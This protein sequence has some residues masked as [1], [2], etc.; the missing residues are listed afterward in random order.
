MPKTDRKKQIRESEILDLFFRRDQKAVESVAADYGKLFRR[1]AFNITRDDMTADEVLNDTYLALWNSIPPERPDNLAAYGSAV[2]RN[3]AVGRV[4]R[5]RAAKR[6]QTVCELD[7]ALPAG[8]SDSPSDD[9]R[10]T[11]L[12]EKFLSGLDSRSRALFVIRYFEEDSLE[13]AAERTGTTVSAVKSNLHRTRIKLRRFLE[14]E[15]YS[16]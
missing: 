10:L 2:A 11:E 7:E 12:L 1:I 9:G 13:S 15:G 5:E 14:R 8:E 6:P 4:R 16:I 3:L